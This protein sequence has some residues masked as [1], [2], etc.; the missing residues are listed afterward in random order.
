MT[1][2]EEIQIFDAHLK[3]LRDIA[4]SLTTVLL[5][6]FY[7]SG[8]DKLQKYPTTEKLLPKIEKHLRAA[9]FS[10]CTEVENAI[11]REAIA[12]GTLPPDEPE[13]EYNYFYKTTTN[14]D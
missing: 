2:E 13:I 6:R 9:L 5:F 12:E 4:D 1:A 7:E 11:Y 8:W 14:K 3:Q 10:C